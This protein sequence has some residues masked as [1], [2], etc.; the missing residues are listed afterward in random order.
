MTELALGADGTYLKSN[1]AAAA[2]TFVAPAGSGTLTTIKEDN[3]GVGGADIV[4]LDFLGADFDLA[5]DPDT[6]VQV[7]IAAAIARD[8]EVAFSDSAD[9][10]VMTTTGSDVHFGD[11]AGTLAGKVEIG[12]DADQPQLVVE[13]HSTQND[14]IVVVQNDADTQ[15]FNIDN[16]GDV[17]AQSIQDIDGPGT[18]WAIASDGTITAVSYGGITEAN[19]VDKAAAESI[20]GAWDWTDTGTFDFAGPVT[21]TSFAADA[22]ATPAVDFDDSD[23][24]GSN[25]DG[26]SQLSYRQ[27]L[28]HDVRGQQWGGQRDWGAEARHNR[29][30]GDYSTDGYSRH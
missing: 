13:G 4:T 29:W 3:A 24:A 30:R 5:E 28:R 7:V 10:V 15:L 12:G 8:A 25:P 6:E 2:P 26:S 23:D 19:L 9:P 17:L 18:N 21:G 1:G 22:S 14:S 16:S 20:S 11:A 27:R